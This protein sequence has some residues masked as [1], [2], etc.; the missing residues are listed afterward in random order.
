MDYIQMLEND[1]AVLKNQEDELRN[2]ANEIHFR[3]QGLEDF[4]TKIK[5]ADI[6]DS[7]SD[8]TTSNA[9]EDVIADALEQPPL[10][11][12]P[13]P[14]LV[15]TKHTMS[16]RKSPKKSKGETSR[17]HFTKL[18]IMNEIIHI[19]SDHQEWK[20][21]DIRKRLNDHFKPEVA[22][23]SLRYAIRTLEENNQIKKADYGVYSLVSINTPENPIAAQS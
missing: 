20:L 12:K 17:V 23:S 13:L 16:L 9:K 15:P 19:L 11:S 3:R 2:Q 18:Q 8:V 21:V 10:I 22:S 14:E 6:T 4:L 5:R 7:E 1:I